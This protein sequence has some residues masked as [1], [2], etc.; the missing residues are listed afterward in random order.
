MKI[1]T[2]TPTHL[3][4]QADLRRDYLISALFMTVWTG[5]WVFSFFVP[6]RMQLNCQKQ[7]TA[8]ACQV[9]FW[10]MLN[11]HSSTQ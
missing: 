6:G 11:L 4:L 1:I 3:L 5:M 10:N 8:A 7:T 2:K 9:T